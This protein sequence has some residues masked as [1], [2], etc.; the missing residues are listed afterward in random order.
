[1]FADDTK[2]FSRIHRKDSAQDISSMHQDINSLASWSNKWQMPFNISKCK[3]LHLGRSAPDHTYQLCNQTIEQ[4][5]EEK[6]LGVI[7]DNQMKYHQHV[8]FATSKAMRMVGF[9]RKTFCSIPIETFLSLYNKLVRPHMEYGN[10]IWG[11]FYMLDQNK[12]EN[13]QRAATRL[14]QSMKHLTY[15]Q[16]I[17]EL[18]L[19]TLKHR[20]QRGDMICVYSLLNNIYMIWTILSFHPSEL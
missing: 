13:L 1:M 9:V 11:P 19:P 5:T 3:F 8:S 16:R 10:V 20:R 7:I 12:I 15:E 6:D 4:V 2:L 14:V 17:H 18:K